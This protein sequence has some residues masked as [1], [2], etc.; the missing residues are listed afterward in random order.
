[1]QANRRFCDIVIFILHFFGRAERIFQEAEVRVLWDSLLFVGDFMRAL[2]S[3]CTKTEKEMKPETSTEGPKMEEGSAPAEGRK[4]EGKGGK[5]SSDTKDDKNLDKSQGASIVNR[6]RR[7][8]R[9][10]TSHNETNNAKKR[11]MA[12]STIGENT[13]RKMQK[14]A[15]EENMADAAVSMVSSVSRL[16]SAFLVKCANM[17]SFIA[18]QTFS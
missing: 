4:I 8:A 15:E 10:S 13:N 18:N 1:M 7:A 14:I 12:E 9:K 3:L 6:K 16:H 11:Q 5:S 17:F 2:V